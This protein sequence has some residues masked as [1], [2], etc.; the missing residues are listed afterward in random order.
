M[1]LIVSPGSFLDMHGY[2]LCFAVKVFY[3]IFS[4][5]N[6]SIGII[7]SL[8]FW[9]LNKTSRHALGRFLSCK[10]PHDKK[11][12]GLSKII[13]SPDQSRK[14]E[15]FCSRRISNEGSLSLEQ[16][17][18]LNYASKFKSTSLNSDEMPASASLNSYHPKPPPS[19]AENCAEQS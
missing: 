9:G 11:P 7:F 1:A 17:P 16:K 19:L 3:F 12:V 15:R 14:A 18:R 4:L 13:Q 5:F 6:G 10:P 8:I 2:K